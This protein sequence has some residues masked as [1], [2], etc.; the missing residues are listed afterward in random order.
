MAVAAAVA[1]ACGAPATAAA[2]EPVNVSWEA[3]LPPIG[4]HRYVPPGPQPGC[5]HA[6]IACVD[7]EIQRMDAW[8]RELGCDHRAVFATTYLRLTQVL[9]DAL[10]RPGTFRSPGWVEYEDALFA[11]S[12]FR[13][14]EDAAAGRSIPAA[15]RIALGA[16]RAGDTT[17]AQDLLL[18]INAHVQ[19]DMPFV[20]AGVGL[21]TKDGTSRKRDHDVVNEVLDAAYEQIVRE[22]TDRYDPTTAIFNSPLT[23]ADDYLGLELVK[24]WREGVWRN[25][26]RLMDA[27]TAADRRRVADQIQRNAET[28]ARM[29]VEQMPGH[30]ARRD[31]YC[32]AHVR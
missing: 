32:A 30:G 31:A 28:T 4:A 16:W 1:T 23:P 13:I 8:R 12:Y 5:A 20:V 18:G 6:S 15:W 22:V 24:T 21:R 9:R 25:A 10:V 2:G 19:A 3:L 26:E 29:L 17:A 11:D 14:S 27:R 7:A